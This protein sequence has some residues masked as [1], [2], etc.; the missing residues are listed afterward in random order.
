MNLTAHEKLNKLKLQNLL[1]KLLL[2]HLSIFYLLIR[3]VFNKAAD[4]IIAVP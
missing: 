3:Q 1:P 4:E 2:S